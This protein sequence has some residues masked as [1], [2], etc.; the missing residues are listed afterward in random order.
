M[1]GITVRRWKGRE[2]ERERERERGGGGG[3]GRQTCVRFC[4]DRQ[5]HR[6][7]G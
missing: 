6:Q 7:V 5:L 3:G 1:V 2:I 4:T